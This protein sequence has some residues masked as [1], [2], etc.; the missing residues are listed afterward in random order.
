[1]LLALLIKFGAF[2]FSQMPINS[3]IRIL[4]LEYEIR[5]LQLMALG[6]KNFL[7]LLEVVQ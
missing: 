6:F 5:V 3:N 1:M 4:D 2:L 7:L